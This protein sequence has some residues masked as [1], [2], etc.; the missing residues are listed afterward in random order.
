MRGIATLLF[1]AALA[2]LPLAATGGEPAP[3]GE[4]EG[5]EKKADPKLAARIKGL[6]KQL[7]DDSYDK[8]EAAS[9]ALLGVGRPARAALEAAAK[10]EDAERSSRARELLEK[11]K[12]LPDAGKVDPKCTNGWQPVHD[13]AGQVQSFTCAIEKVETVRIR[14]ARTYTVPQ[15]DLIIE[16]R[17]PAA[18]KGAEPLAKSTL[19]TDWTD[20]T[21]KP[22]GAKGAKVTRFFHKWK[23]VE[24]KAAKLVKGKTYQLVFSSNTGESAPW[25]VNCFYR[26]TL[27]GGQ[28][29]GVRDRKKKGGTLDLVFELVAGEEKLSS[30]PKGAA[31]TKR[32]H[33]GLGH[34]GTDLTKK[35]GDDEIRGVQGFL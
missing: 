22:A 1:A 21:G 14:V 35:R 18:K 29:L 31:L 3:P 13:R 32:E 7:G 17:D 11:L 28:L 5:K 8:R 27:K 20:W 26:D 33:F 34:D 2:A 4:E 30:V 25:L 19:Y 9:R 23:E 12:R 6:V 10:D 15:D 24:L 16:L